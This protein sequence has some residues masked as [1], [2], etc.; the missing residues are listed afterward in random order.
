MK[1]TKKTKKPT[2]S[3]K[4]TVTKKKSIVV[5][6]KKPVV[7]KLA[8]KKIALKK[9]VTK[10]NQKRNIIIT[11]ALACLAL[12]VIIVPTVANNIATKGSD[13]SAVLGAKAPKGVKLSSTDTTVTVS[14]TTGVFDDGVT[15]YDFLLGGEAYPKYLETSIRGYS[16]SSGHYGLYHPGGDPSLVYYVMIDHSCGRWSNSYSFKF[17]DLLPGKEFSVSIRGYGIKKNFFTDKETRSSSK[18]ITKSIYTA[19]SP[20]NTITNPSKI[21]SAKWYNKGSK[22]AKLIG[23]DVAQVKFASDKANT[24]YNFW[25]TDNSGKQIINIS[26]PN[27]ANS[28]GYRISNEYYTYSNRTCYIAGV[29]WDSATQKNI[30]GGYSQIYN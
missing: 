13:D 7:K 8:V 11:I 6:A 9:L 4:T 16:C 25:C 5:K 22:Q 1:T 19:T 24:W 27:T 21:T 26:I 12:A 20:I 15:E 28:S 30:W 14:W 10:N 29:N 2:A 17:T 23:G 3:K 18:L